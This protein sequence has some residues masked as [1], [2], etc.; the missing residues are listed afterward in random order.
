MVWIQWLW[1]ETAR[2]CGLGPGILVAL[3]GATTEKYILTSKS[4]INQQLD[5][6]AADRGGFVRC[7]PQV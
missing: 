6:S 7:R 3:Q 2:A 1:N 5:I 4:E